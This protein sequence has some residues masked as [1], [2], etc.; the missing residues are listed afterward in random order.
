MVPIPV[1]IIQILLSFIKEF[2]PGDLVMCVRIRVLETAHFLPSYDSLRF[3][4][5]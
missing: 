4:L 5:F 1:A 3:L 2:A